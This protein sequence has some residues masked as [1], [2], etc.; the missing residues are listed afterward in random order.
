VRS[1]AGDFA[2]ALACALALTAG[3]VRAEPIEERNVLAGKAKLQPDKGY[4]YLQGPDRFFG[5]FLRV[6]D[7]ATRA[8]YQRDWEKA[9]ARAQKRYQSDWQRW[10]SEARAAE[11]THGKVRAR[12][13][14]PTREGFTIDPI[15]LRDQIAFGP[16]FVYSKSDTRVDYLNAVKPG[17]YIWYGMMAASAQGTAAGECDCMGTVSFDV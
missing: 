8:D 12:P 15:E 7:E 6:P 17:T 2:T 14:E 5:T 1:A 4:I 16:M 10:Q 9:F 11:Q 13:E 3:A